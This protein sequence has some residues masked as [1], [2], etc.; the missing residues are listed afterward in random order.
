MINIDRCSVVM[1]LIIFVITFL[2]FQTELYH[3]IYVRKYQDNEEIPVFSPRLGLFK[4]KVKQMFMV[5]TWISF[6]GPGED[7]ILKHHGCNCLL[8]KVNLSTRMRG[9]GRPLSGPCDTHKGKARVTYERGQQ[10]HLLLPNPPQ[11]PDS[12]VITT[13]IDS[14]VIRTDHQNSLRYGG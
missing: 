8:S 14:S 11:P 7:M 1:I 3:K 6:A 9:M 12:N 13:T 5:L 2:S 4:N 10:P